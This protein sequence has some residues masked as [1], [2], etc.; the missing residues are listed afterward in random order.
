HFEDEKVAASIEAGANRFSIGIQSF[1]TAVRQRQ[2][3]KASREVAIDFVERLVDR[4]DATVV[5]DMI[6][7]LPL[8]TP[9]VWAQDLLTCS[10]LGPDGVDIYA[11]NVFPTTP[12]HGAIA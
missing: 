6:F 1:D 3:R 5:V 9:E 4:G 11:L 10:G 7:G 8:Q 2:G 12:L